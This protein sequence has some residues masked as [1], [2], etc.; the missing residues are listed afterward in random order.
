MGVLDVL[1]DLQIRFIFYPCCG[2]EGVTTAS[3]FWGGGTWR[4][5]D[6]KCSVH[7]NLAF[8]QVKSRVMLKPMLQ[9]RVAELRGTVKDH[10]SILNP[11]KYI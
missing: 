7:K 6:C 8:S 5:R 2:D 4:N 1:H 10:L 9:S 11:C 3:L